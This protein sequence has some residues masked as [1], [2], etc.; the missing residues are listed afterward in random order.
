M[1]M[2]PH[3]IIHPTQ[4]DF[5]KM[6]TGG[7]MTPY[8]LQIWMSGKMT[9]GGPMIPY[10]I[11]K[12]ISYKMTTGDSKTPYAYQYGLHV[13]IFILFVFNSISMIIF[14][15]WSYFRNDYLVLNLKYYI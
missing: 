13:I 2:R 6:T 14:L 3:D 15:C 5:M 12:W 1:T 7:P 4:M 10:I 11:H 8:T 9:T